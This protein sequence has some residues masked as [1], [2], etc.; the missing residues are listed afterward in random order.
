MYSLVSLLSGIYPFPAL[1]SLLVTIMW[2]ILLSV[3]PFCVSNYQ[4]SISHQGVMLRCLKRKKSSRKRTILWDRNYFVS[5]ICRK[6]RF[7]SFSQRFS[8]FSHLNKGPR[9]LSL[10]STDFTLMRRLQNLFKISH[11]DA[12]LVWDQA[13]LNFDL[14]GGVK[15]VFLSQ[16]FR[17]FS[18]QKLNFVKS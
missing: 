5:K 11:F 12:L 8:S 17:F 15:K 10:I 1:H 7:S 9:L 14:I 16:F 18:E 13:C 3:K 4:F 2:Y 6:R